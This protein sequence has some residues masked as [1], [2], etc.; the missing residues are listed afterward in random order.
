MD[1][2]GSLFRYGDIY[3]GY[4]PLAHVLELG[5]EFSSLYHGVCIG[6]STPLTL[7][8]NSSKIKR[9]AK[10]DCTVLRPTL[11][12]TVPVRIQFLYFITAHL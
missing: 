4:L 7:T 12:A 1:T 3:I 5:A 9:G 11:M 8:D 10:G 6:Y 2:L